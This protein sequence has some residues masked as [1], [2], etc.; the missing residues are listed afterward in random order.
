MLQK[1]QLKFLALVFI[2][3]APFI[4]AQFYYYYGAHKGSTTNLGTLLPNPLN[5]SE[6]GIEDFTKKSNKKWRA[7]YLAPKICDHACEQILYQLQQVQIA[8]GKNIHRFQPIVLHDADKN[9]KQINQKY[10]HTISI[11]I[12][13]NDINMINIIENDKVYLVDPNGNIILSYA[14][15]NTN[16][17]EHLLKDSKKLMNLSKIG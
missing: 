17:A 9:W 12:K 4:A 10:I 2:F 1:N 15:K 11:A 5:T 7:L 13:I 16:F 8:M 14:I 3:I 6:L